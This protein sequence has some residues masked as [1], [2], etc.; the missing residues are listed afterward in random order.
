MF[1]CRILFHILISTILLLGNKVSGTPILIICIP[2]SSQIISIQQGYDSLLGSGKAVAF[3]RIRDFEAMIS[4]TP[5]AAI[6]VPGAYAET[7]NNYKIV[8]RGK[9][10]NSSLQ[11]YF[12]VAATPDITRRNMS[13]KTFG[14]LNFLG[15]T[16]INRFIRKTYG[17]S[18]KIIKQTYKRVDLLNMLGVESV[19][20]LFVSE[21][22]YN[23]IS[24]TTKMQLVTVMTA[25]KT[26]PYPVFAVP[27][28]QKHEE[29]FKII[30]EQPLPLTHALDIEEWGIE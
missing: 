11:K 4:S 20:A 3:G 22:E 17:F 6:I 7:K 26:I 15:R 12:I 8:L 21:S 30:M 19:D 29:L 24:S 14:I 10:D 18:P 9:V 5:E 16:K 28:G 23:E 1:Q 27:V 25:P 13:E 2:G